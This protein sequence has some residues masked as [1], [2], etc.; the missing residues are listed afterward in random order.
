MKLRFKNSGHPDVTGNHKP[1][2]L[3]EGELWL[4]LGVIV[5]SGEDFGGIA[6]YDKGFPH[7]PQQFLMR[8]T[9]LAC[10]NCLLVVE[11]GCLPFTQGGP[12]SLLAK[13][14]ELAHLDTSSVLYD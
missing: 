5:H 1:R 13:P 9:A 6:L 11:N 14:S 3:G 2:H 7:P 12:G 10:P 4:S 8:E